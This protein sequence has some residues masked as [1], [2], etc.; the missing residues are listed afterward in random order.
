[1]ASNDKDKGSTSNEEWL[2]EEAAQEWRNK[3]KDEGDKKS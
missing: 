1:V 3:Q 2:A